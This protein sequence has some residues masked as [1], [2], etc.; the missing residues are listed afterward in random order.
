[1][2]IPKIPMKLVK[3][4]LPATEEAAPPTES[5]YLASFS[6]LT[7]DD[8]A[9]VNLL[10]EVAVQWSQLNLNVTVDAAGAADYQQRLASGDFDM[11]LV[12]LSLGDSA[13]PDVYDFWHQGQYPDGLNYGGMAD[14]R[15]SEMLEKARRDPSG[16]NR[17]ELYDEFQQTFVERAIAIPMYY[18]LFTY[19]TSAHVT[20]VQ[21]GFVGSPADRFSTLRDWQIS[22]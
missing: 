15:I 2:Q 19:V 6:I 11:A 3:Q 17:S 18:P 20:G 12:E 16:I 22:G 21:L 9:L 14:T 7:P 1:M 4:H 5:P 13:D 8:P 10:K